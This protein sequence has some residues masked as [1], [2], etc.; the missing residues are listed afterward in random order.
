MKP[1]GTEKDPSEARS[2]YTHAQKMHA[3]ATFGFGCK[4]GKGQTPWGVNT[5]GEMVGNPSVLEM[6]SC[7]MVSLWQCKVST[8]IKASLSAA[9]KYILG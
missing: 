1:D 4:L 2:G 3:A 9:L 7:Y 8:Q 6:V 5:T